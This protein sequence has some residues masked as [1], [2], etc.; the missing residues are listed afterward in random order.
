MRYGY[1]RPGG[2]NFKFNLG[3]HVQM[4]KSSYSAEASYLYVNLSSA[5]ITHI[6]ATAENVNHIHKRPVGGSL[7]NT[8]LQYQ[9]K[10]L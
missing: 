1:L 3:A 6:S 8:F 7:R 5:S 2:Q 9:C 10:N 4:G